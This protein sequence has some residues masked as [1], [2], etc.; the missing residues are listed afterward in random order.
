MVIHSTTDTAAPSGARRGDSCLLS[1][2]SWTLARLA[3][4]QALAQA[5]ALELGLA[6]A[7]ALEQE[8]ALEQV[9]AAQSTL[10]RLAS[11]LALALASAR[12]LVPA[13]WLELVELSVGCR[14]RWW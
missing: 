10:A 3:S 6:L 5:S 7:L 13:G 14:R 11:A 8:L 9:L 1:V 4:A 12:A 2:F